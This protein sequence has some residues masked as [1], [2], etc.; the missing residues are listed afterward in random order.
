MLTMDVVTEIAGLEAVAGEW[1]ALLAKSATNEPT[2]S[3]TWILNWWRV[4]G[5]TGRR[6]LRAVLL[7]QGGKLVG[8]APLAARPVRSPV[9]LPVRRLEL[10]PSGEE[11][12]DEI[13]SE[14]IGVLAQRGSERAVADQLGAALAGGEL[15]PW[16]E[17]ELPAQNGDTALPLFLVEALRAHGCEARAEITTG[18][19]YV[20]LP[21]RFD[22]YL[23]ALG[24][25]TRYLVRRSL[26]ELE[27][28]AGGPVV[29]RRASTPDELEEGK[30]H[31]RELHESRWAS[32]GQAGVFGSTRFNAFHDA[33]MRDLFEAG[34]LELLWVS[35]GGSAV[36][37]A[38]NIEWNGNVYFYQGGRRP[39]LPPKLR[40]GV[41]IHALAIQAAIAAGRREYHFLGGLSRYK[42][43]LALALRP[44]VRVTATR[45]SVGQLTRGLS[46][47]L[48][49]QGK[50][51]LRRRRGPNGEPEAPSDETS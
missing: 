20:P 16:D 42:M 17:L 35:A 37:A 40:P 8:L 22:D 5:E 25:S 44:L 34:K 36:A 30:R 39:D 45:A 29:L 47:V 50:A 23:D 26:R 27:S 18:A 49:A 48:L 15:G 31:L 4:F 38:Y 6:E 51:F 3:P 11:E 32:D 10:V 28:W 2:L 19:P 24:S 46:A 9:L 33:L 14:F 7:R 41:V 12:A 21:G 13:C 1:Q 43:Q